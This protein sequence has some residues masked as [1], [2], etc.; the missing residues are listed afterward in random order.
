[1]FNSRLGALLLWTPVSIAHKWKP[2]SSI[3][4]NTVK[5]V[6]KYIYACTEC[7]GL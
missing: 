3:T 4:E 1:M 5:F 2:K 7:D 6:H